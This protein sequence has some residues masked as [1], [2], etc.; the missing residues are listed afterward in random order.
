MDSVCCSCFRPGLL[1][2]EQGY[3]TCTA[4]GR[5]HTHLP[6]LAPEPTP[7][8]LAGAAERE[9][10]DE[11]NWYLDYPSSDPDATDSDGEA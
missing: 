3:A 1:V 11:E 2:Y 8:S 7:E 5:V 10:E 4:C 6:H 9:E